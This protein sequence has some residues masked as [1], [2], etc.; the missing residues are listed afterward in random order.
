MKR[1]YHTPHQ[2]GVFDTAFV[3]ICKEK[4]IIYILMSSKNIS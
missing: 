4:K 3:I 1:L 2:Q